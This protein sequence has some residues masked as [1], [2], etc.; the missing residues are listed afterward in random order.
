MAKRQVRLSLTLA[1]KAWVQQTYFCGAA[2]RGGL[3][4]DL[5]WVQHPVVT[6]ICW[7]ELI[8]TITP[9]CWEILKGLPLQSEST[10]GETSSGALTFPSSSPRFDPPT[11]IEVDLTLGCFRSRCVVHLWSL[12][13]SCVYQVYFECIIS[14]TS[15]CRVN[16]KSIRTV[17]GSLQ[18][19]PFTLNFKLHRLKQLSWRCPGGRNR[20]RN[21][22]CSTGTLLVQKF[23]LGLQCCQH[24]QNRQRLKPRTFHRSS[25][26]MLRR[27]I[28]VGQGNKTGWIAHQRS[29]VGKAADER[30]FGAALSCIGRVLGSASGG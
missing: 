7:S 21:L 14:W 15:V 13:G 18:V 30:C 27:Q 8:L 22:S 28:S 11:M 20:S 17:S 23:L 10:G 2:G 19:I 4:L 16:Y 1:P 12:P 29:R 9:S 3:G 24:E 25:Q 5:V 6:A 26:H